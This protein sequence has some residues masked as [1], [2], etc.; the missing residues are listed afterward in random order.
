MCL[1]AAGTVTLNADSGTQ[2][3]T[4]PLSQAT[5]G[6]AIRRGMSYWPGAP[7]VPRVLVTMSGGKLVQ[8]DAGTGT[9]PQ[10][11]VVDLV[12]G[13]MDRIPGGESYTIAPVPS[14]RTSRFPGRTR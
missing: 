5:P 8:L 10:V 12:N 9:R 6:G 1:V 4:F 14:T 3:W 13:I 2:A 7:P 11:G